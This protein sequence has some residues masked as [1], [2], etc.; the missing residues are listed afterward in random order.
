M[1][2]PTETLPPTH[3]VTATP[4]AELMLAWTPTSFLEITGR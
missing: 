1:A 4:T 3:T 2:V